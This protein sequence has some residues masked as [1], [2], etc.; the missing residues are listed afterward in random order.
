VLALK[1]TGLPGCLELQPRVFEDAR[2]RFV[3]VF[4]REL[5]A[6]HGLET[7]FAEEYYSSSLPGVLRGL[8]F[9]TPPHHH[10]KLVY[11][12][13]GRVMDVAVDLRVGSPTYGR[14]AVVELSMERGNAIYLPSGFAHGFY[15]PEGEATLV[16]NVTTG[17]APE[18]D[19]GIRWDSAGIAWPAAA[20]V[21]SDRDAGFPALAEFV[22][23]FRYAG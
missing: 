15:V 11:C 1:E 6:A 18:S 7:S 22:S 9:Q 5:F 13:A 14:H 20:P 3:K 8:H 4:N 12:V 17:Y 19:A 16:Y 23:P 2:G 21:V 10:A